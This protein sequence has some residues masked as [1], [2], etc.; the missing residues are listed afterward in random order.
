MGD[1]LGNTVRFGIADDILAAGDG[2]ETV[3]LLRC[4]LHHQYVRV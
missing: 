2:I 1:L 4:A 3:L